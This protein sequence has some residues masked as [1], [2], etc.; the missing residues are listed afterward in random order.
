MHPGSRTIIVTLILLTGQNDITLIAVPY[1]WDRKT[2]T[3]AATVH[4]AEGNLI[5]PPP[6]AEPIPSSCPH[7]DL[8]KEIP[9]S[10][11]LTWDDVQDVTG[12]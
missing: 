10:H 3:L 9:L 4:Q 1:W 2:D 12:W 6:G 11:G 8:S 5:S 7:D